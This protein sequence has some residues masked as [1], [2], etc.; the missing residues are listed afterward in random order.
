MGRRAQRSLRGKSFPDAGLVDSHKYPHVRVVL[1]NLVRN[2]RVRDFRIPRFP[3]SP[4]VCQLRIESN[5]ASA[6]DRHNLTL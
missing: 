6:M 2:F 5:A 3:A 4:H 1:D